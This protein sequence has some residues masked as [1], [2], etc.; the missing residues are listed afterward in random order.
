MDT[1]P[2]YGAGISMDISM[3]MPLHK[4]LLMSWCGIMI[5]VS[6]F[7]VAEYR[8]F[9]VQAQQL[10]QLKDDYAQHIALLK[11]RMLEYPENEEVKKKDILA[12]ETSKRLLLV[13]R[14]VKHLKSSAVS[15][16][17]A[18]DLERA[19][20]TLYEERPAK[21]RTVRKA[22][23]RKSRAQ[24]KLAPVDAQWRKL[25]REP[26]FKYPLERSHF[27]LSSPYGPRKNPQGSWEF[28]AGIDMAASRG[29][30]VKAAGAGVVIQATFAPGYGN[31]ILIEHD[32]KFRTRY[33]HLDKIFVHVGQH[34][35]QGDYIGKVGATGSVRKSRRGG[36]G[37]H[38]HFEVYVFG[39]HANPF[40]FLA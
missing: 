32:T 40:Y 31:T 11:K 27:W 35:K 23:V 28:H 10:E 19:V 20:K 2:R 15:F 1:S 39:K 8:F 21:A 13:N 9:K 4:L 34:V 6:G 38:L 7:L 12:S 36:N 25:Q 16:A 3:N 5:V 17:R 14:A 33:A 37:S 30:P 24:A 22:K 29:T 26:I 18:H